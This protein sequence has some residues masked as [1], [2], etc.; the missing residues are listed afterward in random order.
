[1][2]TFNRALWFSLS[3]CLTLVG[4][5]GQEPP[6]PSNDDN[7]PSIQPFFL[8]KNLTPDTARPL[9][10]KHYQTYIQGKP[11]SATHGQP[12]TPSEKVKTGTMPEIGIERVFIFDDQTDY[13]AY[14]CQI[15]FEF[16]IIYHIDKRTGSIRDIRYGQSIR[17]Q[18]VNIL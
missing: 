3:A 4:C 14:Y 5:S 13:W 7:V 8:G 12:G 15:A 9:V 18:P 1:M 10:L 17:D 11:F 2:M 16:Y 6:A